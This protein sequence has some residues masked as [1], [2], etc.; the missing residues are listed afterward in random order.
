MAM[1]GQF[2]LVPRNLEIFD[3]R[4]F[5]PGLRDD[6]IA[7]LTL[8]IAGIGLEF[9]GMMHSNMKQIAI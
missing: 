6:V 2:L 3:D 8:R 5:W 4:L 9:G 7:T 1:H